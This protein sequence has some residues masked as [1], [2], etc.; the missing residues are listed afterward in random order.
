MTRIKPVGCAIAVAKSPDNEEQE[1]QGPTV[2]D[3]GAFALINVSQARDLSAELVKGVV[4]ANGDCEHHH[5]N[6][7]EVVWYVERAAVK[8]GDTYVVPTSYVI[9]KEED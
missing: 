8:L 4:T 7:G 5:F 3:M 9:A 6:E 2:I 1:D